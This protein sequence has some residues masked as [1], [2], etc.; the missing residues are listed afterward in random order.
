MLI[1][2]NFIN[3]KLKFILET[4]R[5]SLEKKLIAKIKEIKMPFDLAVNNKP[6][7]IIPGAVIVPSQQQHI[8]PPKYQKRDQSPEIIDIT[9]MTPK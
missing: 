2:F 8:T 7:I 3:I 4:Q 5:P 6:Q 9:P 1:K